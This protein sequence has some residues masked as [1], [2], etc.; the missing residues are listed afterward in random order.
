MKRTILITGANGF[1][2]E[3]YVDHLIK[4]KHRVIAVDKHFFNLIK[5]KSEKNFYKFNFN[6]SSENSLK[7]LVL[8]IKRKKL[9]VD[10]IINNAAIDAIPKKNK[11]SFLIDQKSWIN[12]VNT[13]LY[14]STYL[15]LYFGQS[16]PKDVGR[17]INIGSDLSVIAPNQDIYKSYSGY[18]KPASYSVIKHGMLGLTKYLASLF[19]KNGVSVNMLSPGPIL[20]KQNKKLLFELKKIIPRHRLANKKDLLPTLD[21]L[22]DKN[23]SYLTGQNIVVDGGRTII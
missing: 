1:L 21:Y 17:I 14:A 3:Y 20:N 11:K 2:G 4:K 22:L 15:S 19:A 13:S 8:E 18:I 16:M 23:N 12:E 10:T 6:I 9:K 7:K 5:Y